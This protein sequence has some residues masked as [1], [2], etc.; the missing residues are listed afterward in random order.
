M[1]PFFSLALIFQLS[2]TCVAAYIFCFHCWTH[3]VPTACSFGILLYYNCTTVVVSFCQQNI[4]TKNKKA[5]LGTPGFR[6]GFG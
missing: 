6:V 2:R 4:A 3:Q 5:V 1:P